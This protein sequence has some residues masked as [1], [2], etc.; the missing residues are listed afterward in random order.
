MRGFVV[1]GDWH[2]ACYIIVGL[3]P[4]PTT[5]T[6]RR[7]RNEEIIVWN[8]SFGGA[9]CVSCH[10]NGTGQCS[11]KCS[12]SAASADSICWTTEFGCIARK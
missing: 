5:K 1:Y 8:N 4:T 12:C 2:I 6:K 3:N 10:V 11:G 7:M 9:D